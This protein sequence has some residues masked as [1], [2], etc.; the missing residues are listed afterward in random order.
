[1]AGRGRKRRSEPQYL[2]DMDPPEGGIEL[3]VYPDGSGNLIHCSGAYQRR[4]ER[5]WNKQTKLWMQSQ[6]WVDFGPDDKKTNCFYRDTA[7]A[8]ALLEAEF[9]DPPVLLPLSE[10][11]CRLNAEWDDWEW[12]RLLISQDRTPRPALPWGRYV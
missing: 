1:M 2:F 10:Y 9:E 6:V 11:H 3:L 7:A 12:R 8:R 5:G 4:C